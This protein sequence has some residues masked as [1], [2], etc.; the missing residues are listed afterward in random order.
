MFSTRSVRIESNISFNL[1]L[2]PGTFQYMSSFFSWQK[3]R[4]GLPWSSLGISF[5]FP[6]QPIH[7]CRQVSSEPVLCLFL[8]LI[9]KGHQRFSLQLFQ[10]KQ[11]FKNERQRATELLLKTNISIVQVQ[12]PLLQGNCF[13]ATF[14]YEKKGV[15]MMPGLKYQI[16]SLCMQISIGKTP[17][18]QYVVQQYMGYYLCEY[19][20]S[21][22]ESVIHVLLYCPLYHL[23]HL[24]LINPIQL[25]F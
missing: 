16:T 10:S 3:C 18:A 22:L 6:V 9:C 19:Q 14:F 15:W 4:C 17:W 13:R 8:V 25:F 24:T 7:T 23:Q 21:Q 1:S 11:Q 5:N 2:T 12:K 20:M